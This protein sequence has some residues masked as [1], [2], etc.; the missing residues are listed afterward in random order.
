MPFMVTLCICYDF[1]L[2]GV[3]AALVHGTAAFEKFSAWAKV[4]LPGNYEELK[5]AALEALK[6]AREAARNVKVT[7]QQLK[8]KY[9]PMLQEY[10]STCVFLQKQVAK[11]AELAAS[12]KVKVAEKLQPYEPQLTQAWEKV[13]E[14]SLKLWEAFMC[15]V[16]TCSV[17]GSFIALQVY[18]VSLQAYALS[19]VKVDYCLEKGSEIAQKVYVDAQPYLE[20]AKA[21]AKP[22]AEKALA[23]AKEFAA[24]VKSKHFPAFKA[25]AH[26]QTQKLDGHLEAGL[27]AAKKATKATYAAAKA[28]WEK[29]SALLKAKA[30]EKTATKS[31][32]A[33]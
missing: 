24:D 1:M 22:A 27:E 17:A 10:Y 25:W 2:V 26:E 18:E 33:Q 9:L 15:F 4:N 12:V 5:K 6:Q 32:K 21:Q 11:G 7:F 8:E 30:Q 19:K 3:Q 23:Q 31:K 28:E 13:C 29:Q 16:V 14:N 20:K